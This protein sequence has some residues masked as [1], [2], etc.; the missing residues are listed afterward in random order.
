MLELFRINL[1]ALRLPAEFEGDVPVSRLTSLLPMTDIIIDQKLTS[2]SKYLSAIIVNI[3]DYS[4]RLL[5]L[6]DEE[7]MFP[8]P[9][10]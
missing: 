9:K 6:H 8:Q 5:S 2:Q 3:F 4:L 10:F 7:A 1:Q